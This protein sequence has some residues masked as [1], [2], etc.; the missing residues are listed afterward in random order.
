MTTVHNKFTYV[1]QSKTEAHMFYN[2]SKGGV[3]TFDMMCASSDIGRKTA[4]WPMCVFYGLCNLIVN[5]AYIIYAHTAKTEGRKVEKMDFLQDMAYSLCKPLALERLEKYGRWLSDELKDKIKSNFVQGQQVAVAAV[6]PEEPFTGVKRGDI[7]KRCKYDARS[8][9]YSG[10][11]LC[12]GKECKKQPICQHHSVLLCKD[13]Y[14][15][16]KHLL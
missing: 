6:D 11:N 8:S 14:E 12:H 3:D 10:I 5:N 9:H 7:K 4:R 1:E 16:V 2:A 13:C 15:K